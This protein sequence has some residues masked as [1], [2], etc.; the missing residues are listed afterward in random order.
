[1][2]HVLYFRAYVHHSFTCELPLLVFV[3]LNGDMYWG[4][5]FSKMQL[6]VWVSC[7]INIVCYVSCYYNIYSTTV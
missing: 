7:I 3:S 5:I 1:M 4:C 6:C 2:L